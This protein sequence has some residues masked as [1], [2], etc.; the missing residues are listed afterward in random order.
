M[1]S[2]ILLFL[3]HQENRHLLARMLAAR[4][5]VLLPKSDKAINEAFDLCILD[6]QA[7]FRLQKRVKGRKAAEATF[8]PFLLVTPRQSVRIIRRHL[9]KTVDELLISPIEQVEL[10]TRVEISLRTRQLSLDLQ[11]QGEDKYRHLFDNAVEGIFQTTP[12]G[13]LLTA[14]PALA[15]ML[16]YVSPEELMRTIIDFQQQL[17]VDPAKRLE[18]KRQLDSTGVVQGFEAQ[19]YRKDGSTC[20]NAVNT[21]AV[22]G[23][24][25]AVLYY[26]GRVEDISERKSA[27]AALRKMRQSIL[28]AQEAERSRIA[29]EL[30]DDVCQRLSATKLH[31]GA[32]TN[33]LGPNNKAL[34]PKLRIIKQQVD[35]NIIEVRRISLHL[36]PTALDD[37]GLIKALRQLCNE[38]KKDHHLTISLRATNSLSAFC[39][40]AMGIALYRIV[41]EGLSNISKHARA[42]NVLVKLAKRQNALTLDIED[43][44][45]GFIPE[46]VKAPHAAGHQLGLLNMKERAELLGGT[47]RVE[48]ARQKGTKIHVEIPLVHAE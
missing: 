24:R 47:F 37:L 44:G 38:F 28:A 8:L 33:S 18:F 40:A 41:Q 16:G 12:D 42:T 23:A 46:K 31:L 34:L 11:R 21:R 4:Y 5:E 9:G 45:K 30:H 26:E 15:R 22:R 17:F 48:S 1:M 20:W 35:K 32:L 25:G 3:D 43:N 39:D 10:Q 19:L 2:K 27:E 13:R 6:G 14:N 36:R 29:R 7:L